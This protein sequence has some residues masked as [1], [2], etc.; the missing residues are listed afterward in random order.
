MGFRMVYN[1]LTPNDLLGLKVKFKT[2]ETLKSKISTTVR[3]REMVS[4]EVK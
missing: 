4:I 3:D 2:L 1:F